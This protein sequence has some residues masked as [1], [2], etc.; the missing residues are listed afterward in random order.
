MKTIKLKVKNLKKNSKMNY[1]IISIIGIDRF[2]KYIS[3]KS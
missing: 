1:K 2:F 3:T